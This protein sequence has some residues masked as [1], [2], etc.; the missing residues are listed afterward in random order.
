MTI[1]QLYF[2]KIIMKDME[3]FVVKII[4]ITSLYFL[5]QLV[6]KIILVIQFEKKHGTISEANTT[7]K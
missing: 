1:S 3:Y 7:L 4:T 5:F 6:P 2:T